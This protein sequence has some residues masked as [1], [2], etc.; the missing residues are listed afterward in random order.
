MNA[1]DAYAI[2]EQFKKYFDDRSDVNDGDYG[3]PVPNKE[4]TYARDCDEI[5][6]WLEKL[7]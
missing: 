1:N 2:I 6:T 4:M 7:P 3:E 5:L